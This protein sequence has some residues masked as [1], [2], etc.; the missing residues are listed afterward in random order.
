MDILQRLEMEP[1]PI[2]IVTENGSKVR[3]QKSRELLLQQC[4]RGALGHLNVCPG[5]ER[6]PVVLQLRTQVIQDG[7]I[8]QKEIEPDG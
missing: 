6:S 2:Q 4:G 3:L 1:G 8:R 5:G 7:S